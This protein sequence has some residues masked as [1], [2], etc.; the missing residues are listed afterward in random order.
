MI[1]KHFDEGLKIAIFSNDNRIAKGRT[2]EMSSKG[3]E[4]AIQKELG[5][6]IITYAAVENDYYRKPSVDMFKMLEEYYNVKVKIGKEE[7]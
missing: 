7:S 4:K 1:K 3:K 2:D 5:V 6:N